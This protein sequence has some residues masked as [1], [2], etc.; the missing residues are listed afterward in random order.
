[1]RKKIAAFVL[2]CV[3][4]CC[5]CPV[6]PAQ[7]AFTPPFEVNADAVYMVNLDTGRVVYEKN[8]K[9]A[10]APASLTKMMTSLLLMENCADL[11]GTEVTAPGYI[12]DEMFGL[13]V[14]NADIRP[15]ET[16][17]AETLLYA[18]LLPS[19]NEAASIT[20]DYL[21]GGNLD[22]FFFT[23]NA[24]A[25]QLGCVNTNFTNAHGI[26]GMEENHYSCAYDMYL[27]A[28]ACYDTPGFME[29]ASS[30]SYDMPFTNKHTHPE[31]ASKPDCA[32]T[33]RS[34]NYLQRTSSKIYRSDVHGLKTGSTP[35]AG[36]N[37]ASTATRNGE[38]Y[39]LIVMGTPYELD[40]YGYGLSF[41]VSSALYDWA[42]ANFSVSPALDV[43]KPLQ[44]VPVKYSDVTDTVLLYPEE[45][46]ATLLPNEADESVLQKTYLLPESVAAPIKKGDVIGAVKLSLAGEE[47]GTVALVSHTDIE[48]S[49]LLY[50]WAQLKEFAGSLY[51]RTV[52]ILLAILIAAYFVMI[53][54]L[55]RRHKMQAEGYTEPRSAPRRGA[56]VERRISRQR[57]PRK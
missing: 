7:A 53:H 33:I 49:E 39:M 2:C 56:P 5:L 24:R 48:R 46:F 20:A 4:V 15:W 17:T 52:L 1:M 57:R 18:M 28:K 43:D 34:T 6:Q 44:E 23:M 42:F 38:T 8:A 9:K 40:E 51:F 25:K 45:S 31:Y 47:L 22:N 36:Y 3:L 27:I 55:E 50:S 10:R 13:K 12:Y 30:E 37:L 14:S 54:L 19:G 21:G 29:V 41:S 32:Y 16:V 11:A 26:W 35:D